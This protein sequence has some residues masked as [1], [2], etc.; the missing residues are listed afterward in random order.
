MALSRG[1]R[2]ALE[3]LHAQRQLDAR[4]GRGRWINC[5]NVLLDAVTDNRL[6]LADADAVF[7]TLNCYA[8]YQKRGVSSLAHLRANRKR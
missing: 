8:G 4:S 3:D 5:A 2:V 1:W 7:R 6:A